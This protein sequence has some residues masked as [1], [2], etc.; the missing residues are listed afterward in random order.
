LLVIFK[1]FCL[2]DFHNYC[3]DWLLSTEYLPSLQIAK[4]LTFS[5]G[6]YGQFTLETQHVRVLRWAGW[7]MDLSVLNGIHWINL[8]K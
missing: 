8:L 7:A 2:I 1:T 3:Y 6:F 4:T 5:S